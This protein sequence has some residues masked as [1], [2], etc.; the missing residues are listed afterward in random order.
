MAKA[1]KARAKATAA[2]EVPQTREQVVSA[3]AEI[4]RLQRERQR[5]E[6]QMNDTLAGVRQEF[7]DRAQPLGERARALSAGVQI[8]CEA[9]RA[10][11]TEGGRS[12]TA[13]L[14]SGE[15]RWR[16]TPGKVLLRNVEAVL[17]A[18]RDRGLHR[19]IR[20]KD[21][22]NK[23]AMLAEPEM[24]LRVPGV[25]IAQNEEFEILPFET[26]LAEVS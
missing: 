25:S 16:M 10:E 12:K 3:I 2:T 6:A 22:P 15:V 24:A 19:F 5:I 23:E 7:E 8:W 21:E 18:L 20:T 9:H 11:L 26:A 13:T 1:T 4:G 17:Q 14:P